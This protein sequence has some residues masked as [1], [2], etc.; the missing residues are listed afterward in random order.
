MILATVSYTTRVVRQVRRILVCIGMSASLCV[1][2]NAVAG[3]PA[4]ED[5]APQRGTEHLFGTYF[6]RSE[7]VLRALAQRTP[8]TVWIDG[9][10]MTLSAQTQICGHH[11][12]LQFGAN[13]TRNGQPITQPKASVVCDNLDLGELNGGAWL[14]Y[15]GIGRANRRV[16][17]TRIDVWRQ[18]R[19]KVSVS[20]QNGLPVLDHQTPCASRA[21]HELRYPHEGSISVVCDANV[22]G[23]VQHVLESLLRVPPLT[24]AIHSESNEGAMVY[25]VKPFK[26]KRNDDYEAIDGSLGSIDMYGWAFYRNPRAGSIVQQI[27]FRPDGTVLV[28]ETVLAH[29]NNEAECAALFSYALAAVHQQIIQQ[30]ERVQKYRPD[31]W[32]FN[33]EKN[34]SDNT[35]YTGR[36]IRNINEKTLRLGIRQMYLAGYDIREA[37]FAWA[38]A[39]GK[40]VKNPII[41]SKHPDK[42][43]PWYATYAFNYI[44]QYYQDVDYSKLKRGEKEYQQFL[45]ELRKADPEA[46]ANQ[47]PSPKQET[48]SR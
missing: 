12:I 7:R 35:K 3:V 10:P 21:P 32:S 4:H 17:G 26:V 11:S 38:V 25:V 40:P 15:V 19:G 34:G 20:S 47:K 24:E 31:R 29:L 9:Y 37:P 43:I 14:Q 23:Y 18:D 36:Y 42:E 48:K 22:R 5:V 2:V 13:L 27:V 41:N 8:E 28:P 46:F 1:S 39:E 33:N 44:S 45:Q 30:L 6:S 16:A